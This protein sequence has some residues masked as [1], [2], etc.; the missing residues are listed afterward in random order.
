MPKQAVN[1]IGNIYYEAR[2]EASEFKD[3]KSREVVAEQ[4]GIEKR[5]LL[6]IENNKRNPYPE[7]VVRMSEF[8]EAPHIIEDFCKNKCP[9]GE[10]LFD[11]K[12]V[13]G[14]IFKASV[15]TVAG[16]EHLKGAVNIL[17]EALKDGVLTKEEIEEVDECMEVLNE[18]MDSLLNLKIS[19]AKEKL[20][21]RR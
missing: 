16:M 1:A 21:V 4:V 7:E 20:K 11:K 9:I 6:A 18:F 2:M 17:L 3:C 12:T 13:A 5:R 8:Y 15:M 19:Y 14:D 10:K